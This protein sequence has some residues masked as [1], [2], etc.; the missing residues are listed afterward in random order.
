MTMDLDDLERRYRDWPEVKALIAELREARALI[1]RYDRL[2]E[3]AREV[4]PV[5]EALIF[6]GDNTEYEH[7]LERPG[8]NYELWTATAKDIA[9][10]DVVRKLAEEVEE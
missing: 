8:G 5:V 1:A 4:K 7:F 3:A 6:D 9:A 2:R 10:L